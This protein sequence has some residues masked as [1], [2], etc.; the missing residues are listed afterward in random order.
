[1]AVTPKK[2]EPGK[3]PVHSSKGGG[4][5]AADDK[6][7]GGADDGGDDDADKKKK[8][9]TKAGGADDDGDAGDGAHDDDEGADDDESGGGSGDDED[10]R[11]EMAGGDPEALKLLERYTSKD[12]VGKALLTATQKAREKGGGAIKPPADDAP[13]EEWAAFNTEHYGR[14]AKIEDLKFEP[15]LPDNEELQDEEA[16]LLTGVLGTAF[17]TGIFGK[18][19]LDTIGQMVTDMV[20]GGRLELG[21]RVTKV[22]EASRAALEKAWGKGDVAKNLEFAN[23][24]AAMRCEQAGVDPG[25]LSDLRLQDGSRL[26]D[27]PLYAQVMALGGR[28]HAEDPGMVREEGAPGGLGDLKQQLQTEMKK[29][30]G[31]KAEQKEYA[32]P[33]AAA[34]RR[35][36]REA[37]KKAGGSARVANPAKAAKK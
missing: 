15:K 35:R 19:Q 10:W 5:A 28:D 8:K 9:P 16:S 32:S 12:Q 6:G 2:T 29:M 36:L 30:T 34:K 25:A 13:A 17:Q 22:Q 18:K 1:M 21:K 26:G 4:G 20:V 31:T 23:S 3:S 11:T 7:G 14:P 37:I 24:Y 33:E 27:N